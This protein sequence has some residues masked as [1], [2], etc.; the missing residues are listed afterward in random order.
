MILPS[1]LDRSKCHILLNY[2]TYKT[3]EG[4]QHIRQFSTLWLWGLF[5]ISDWL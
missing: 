3:P 2:L 1:R 5:L 4:S